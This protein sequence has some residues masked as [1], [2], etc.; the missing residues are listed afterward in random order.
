[1]TLVHSGVEL[2]LVWKGAA[3]PAPPLVDRACAG[4]P[5]AD[6][7]VPPVVGLPEEHCEKGPT[8][9]LNSD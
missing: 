6:R 9:A 7:G 4:A 3:R 1:M 5:R 2:R 8:M